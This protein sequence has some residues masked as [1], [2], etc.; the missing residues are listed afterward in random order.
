L[1]R[2]DRTVGASIEHAGRTLAPVA[3][4]FRLSLPGRS[5]GLVWNRPLGIAVG[6]PSERKLLRIPDRTRQIQ[7]LLWGTGLAVGLLVRKIARR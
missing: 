7:W 3:A 4:A 1:I 6:P 2:V 5:G